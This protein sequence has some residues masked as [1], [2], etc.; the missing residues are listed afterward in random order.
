M[1][2]QRLPT[3][4]DGFTGWHSYCHGPVYKGERPNNRIW[5]TFGMDSSIA[6]LPQKFKSNACLRSVTRVDCPIKARLLTSAGVRARQDDDAGKSYGREQLQ[7]GEV[8]PV[9]AWKEIN[10]SSKVYYFKV[11]TCECFSKTYPQDQ[12]PMM[13]Q[14]KERNNKW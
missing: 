6:K 11:F 4:S 3:S 5:K 2:K 10:A 1:A 14:V 9:L 8:F 12:Q 13:R 7:S